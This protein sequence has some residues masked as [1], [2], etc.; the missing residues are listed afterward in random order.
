MRGISWISLLALTLFL[1]AAAS[2]EVTECD[3]LT[4]N[5]PD[6]DRVAEGVPRSQIDLPT[7]IAAC[8]TA[9][10]AEPDVARFAY[11][12]GRVYFYDGDVPQALNY[13]GRAADQG[14][15]PTGL[16]QNDD[17]SGNGLRQC[18]L[19]GRRQRHVAAGA[20]ARFESC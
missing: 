9:L 12:L 4:A 11:Q 7:A 3:R 18:H 6:P 1:T 13:M 15:R 10:A 17:R 20:R 16:E 19:A 5:P 2:A 8:K 14:S